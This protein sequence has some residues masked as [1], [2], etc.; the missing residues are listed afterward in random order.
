MSNIRMCLTVIYSKPEQI[1]QT[2]VRGASRVSYRSVYVCKQLPHTSTSPTLHTSPALHTL[3]QHLACPTHLLQL[4]SQSSSSLASRCPAPRPPQYSTGT[5]IYTYVHMYSVV[6]GGGG[7]REG[8]RCEKRG[9]RREGGKDAATLV[10]WASPGE[11][12]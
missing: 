7:E 1:T 8:S 10:Q 2:A 11:A 5:N 12:V 3:H 9:R 4:S 6:C